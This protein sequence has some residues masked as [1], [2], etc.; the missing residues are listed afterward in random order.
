MY[1][2]Y[3]YLDHT[4]DVK[5]KAYGK[6]L[7]DCFANAAKAMFNL[8]V[9]LNKI[10]IELRQNIKIKAENLDFLLYK[11]LSELLYLFYGENKLFSEFEI[12]IIRDKDGYTLDSILYGESVKD[13]HYIDIEIKAVTLHDLYVKRDNNIYTCQ[14]V[15]DV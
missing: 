12:S 13:T 8:I 14:V 4:A 1:D 2:N 10:N 6:T 3:I 7:E 11:W 9:P 15:L 5:F